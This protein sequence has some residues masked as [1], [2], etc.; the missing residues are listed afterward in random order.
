[1][2]HQVVET[3][4]ITDAGCSW[5]THPTHA[6]HR[7]HHPASSKARI[8]PTCHTYTP[9]PRR[10]IVW[11]KLFGYLHG[12]I[13]S[14]RAPAGW[15]LHCSRRRSLSLELFD[16]KSTVNHAQGQAAPPSAPSRPVRGGSGHRPSAWPMDDSWGIKSHIMI[17]M[18]DQFDKSLSINMMTADVS[19]PSAPSLPVRGDSGHRPSAWPGGG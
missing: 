1:M 5:S 3:A 7:R 16:E 2:P 9:E 15:I 11:N 10:F 18:D 13:R 12:V 17:S 14:L 19:P 4:S 8:S 6:R